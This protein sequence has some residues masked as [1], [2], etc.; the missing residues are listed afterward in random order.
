MLET[1]RAQHRVGEETDP[2]TGKVQFGDNVVVVAMEHLNSAT[3]YDG[4]GGYVC[5]RKE[6]EDARGFAIVSST[7][8]EFG[9]LQTAS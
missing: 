2:T 5:Q 1:W 4:H 3:E 6:R 8:D 9:S 7:D